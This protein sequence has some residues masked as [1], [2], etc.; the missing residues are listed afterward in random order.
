VETHADALYDEPFRFVI[1]D[2]AALTL[3][4]FWMGVSVSLRQVHKLR[5]A[6]NSPLETGFPVTC[7][8]VALWVREHAENPT[9][10]ATVRGL[11]LDRNRGRF[12]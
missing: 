12:G 9:S 11:M 1:R 7:P 2:S 4:A 5:A 6:R 8:A 3:H 10:Q